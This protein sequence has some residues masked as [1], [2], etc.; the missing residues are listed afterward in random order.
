[1][2]VSLCLVHARLV[3][4]IR[5]GGSVAVQQ[6]EQVCLLKV[7][8]RPSLHQCIDVEEH[9]TREEGCMLLRAPS[10]S[11]NTIAMGI[12]QEDVCSCL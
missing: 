2:L 8:H 6:V 4:V 12:M 3:L 1:M 5:V 10:L 9:D 11:C 7:L